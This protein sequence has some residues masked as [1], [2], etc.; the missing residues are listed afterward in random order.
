MRVTVE[1]TPGSSTPALG[2]AGVQ[3]VTLTVPVADFECPDEE[4]TEHFFEAMRPAKFS[5]I[6]FQLESHEASPQGD[7]AGGALT[8]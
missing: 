2:F 3:S 6:T 5:E 7:D 8:I 1:V 4:M